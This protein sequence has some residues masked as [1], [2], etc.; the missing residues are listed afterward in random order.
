M[1]QVRRAARDAP[2]VPAAV[3]GTREASSF[4]LT[5]VKAVVRVPRYTYDARLTKIGYIYVNF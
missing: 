3:T 4:D 1:R 2:T 5:P